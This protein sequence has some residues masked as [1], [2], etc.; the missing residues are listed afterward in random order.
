MEV[1][2]VSHKYP[3]AT[4]GMEKQ[5]YELIKGVGRYTKVHTIVFEGDGSRI[6]F[7]TRLNRRIIRICKENP[8]ISLIHFNDALIGAWSLTHTGYSHLKRTMTVHGLDIVFPSF[9]YQRFVLPKFNKFDLIIA[10]SQATADACTSRGIAED[11]IKVVNNGVGNGISLPVARTDADFLLQKKFQINSTG[12]RLL[13]SLG[14]QVKRKGFSW[15]LRNVIPELHDDFIYLMVGPTI[16]P[17]DPT[18]RLLKL[19]PTTVKN[20]IEL[21]LGFPGDAEA[22]RGL[23]N[24]PQISAKAKLLGKLTADDIRILLGAADAFIMPNIKVEGDMEGFGLVCLEASLLGTRVVA[25]DIEGIRDAVHNEKN[26][27]LLPSGDVAVWTRTLNQLITHPESLTLQREDVARYTRQHF[28]LERMAQ[29][30]F[31]LFKQTGNPP[32]I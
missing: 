14:R 25:S 27:Y 6:E 7:F 20:L 16:S 24:D 3:P 18:A 15:F 10:V 5:S 17:S 29:S 2:F 30:Y 12:K 1:L 19:L 32:D 21:F 23:F 31:S 8:G 28:S 11:K 26:G 22:I 9:L 13:I 4:G